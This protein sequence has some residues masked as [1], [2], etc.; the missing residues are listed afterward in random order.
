MTGA[1]TSVA[2]KY[3]NKAIYA[4]KVA[5]PEVKLQ[6]AATLVAERYN[7]DALCAT[8]VAAPIGLWSGRACDCF[9]ATEVAS[10]LFGAAVLAADESNSVAPYV[11]TFMFPS[12]AATS[13]A[14]RCNDSAMYATEVAA[15]GGVRS[16]K[17][18]IYLMRL[19]SHPR[20]V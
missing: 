3:D 15:P 10:P 6:G 14:D 8:E 4:T 5:S 1:A 9:Y 13:V 2:E 18:C 12:G 19:K 20:G 11:N 16:R 17:A 7:S